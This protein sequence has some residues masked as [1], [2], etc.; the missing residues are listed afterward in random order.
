MRTSKKKRT[1]NNTIQ[2]VC[3]FLWPFC[4][5]GVWRR[6]AEVR[7]HCFKTVFSLLCTWS[8]GK[9]FPKLT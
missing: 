5:L 4:Y 2:T 9:Q 1:I 8:Q 3:V 6:G 7:K